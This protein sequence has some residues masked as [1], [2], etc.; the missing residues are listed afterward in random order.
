M[1][2]ASSPF[3]RNYPSRA[4]RSPKGCEDGSHGTNGIG[5]FRAIGL[6]ISYLMVHPRRLRWR[7]TICQG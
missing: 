7:E 3:V 5:E 6:I 2:F 1:T 4:G